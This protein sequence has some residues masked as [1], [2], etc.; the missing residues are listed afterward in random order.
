M[1]VR[2]ELKENLLLL[3]VTPAI[4]PEDTHLCIIWDLDEPISL[5]QEALDLRPPH[6]HDHSCTLIILNVAILVLF[7]GRGYITLADADEAE[8]L[9]WGALDICPP[10]SHA[11]RAVLFVIAFSCHS[12]EDDIPVSRVSAQASSR[13]WQLPSSLNEP[14]RLLRECQKQDDPRLLEDVISQFIRA[15]SCF[16]PEGR[17]W[18]VLQ[19]NIIAAPVM[20]FELQGRM[21]DA[22]ST[23]FEQRGDVK[24]LDEA[25]QHHRLALQLI[26]EGHPDRS[27]SLSNLANLNNLAN[28]M[29]TQFTQQG[30]RKDLDEAIQ[31]HRIALQLRP[32]GHPLRSSSLNN[33]VNAL[34]TQFTQRGDRKDLKEAIQLSST[35]AQQSLAH[36]TYLHAH[37]TLANI[38][39]ALWRSQHTTQ[40]LN[41]AMDHYRPA[42]NGLTTQ[43]NIN[44]S[45]LDV[46]ALSLQLLGSH[47]STTTSVLSRHQARK[48]LPHD[49]SVDAASCALRQGNACCAVELLEQGRALHWA[50]IA[51]FRTSLDDL[52]SRDA[53]AEMLV[54]RF[55]DLGAMLNRPDQTSFDEG[56]SVTTIEAEAQHHRDLVEEWNNVVE[57]IRTFEGF[58]RFLLPPLFADLREAAREG[59]VIILIG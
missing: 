59:P 4:S 48:H 41:D 6:H 40:D 24:D 58:S 18:V 27:S 30:D 1:F 2:I 36:P 7:R 37:V 25:I 52:R 11:Y 12:R 47:I 56:R 57:E 33:S 23:R 35:A 43:K 5:F 31:Y 39:L 42:Y 22:L 29:S 49:L 50:Q 14:V 20:R 15:E 34:S 46:Y 3:F 13:S 19:K 53:H 21:Q 44:T 55:R 51:S 17:E 9:L 38:H 26:P 8:E 16:V 32:E 45:A 54:K 28:A 10:E